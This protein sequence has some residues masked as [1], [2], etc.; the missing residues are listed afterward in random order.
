MKYLDHKSIVHITLFVL[1]FFVV[2]FLFF[3]LLKFLPFVKLSNTLLKTIFFSG[4]TFWY[5]DIEINWMVRFRWWMNCQNERADPGTRVLLSTDSPSIPLFVRRK[6]GKGT[7]L[8]MKSSG[9]HFAEK[10]SCVIWG[11]SSTFCLL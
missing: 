6:C 9:F 5:R 1:F 7:G 2:L 10:H 3:A 4:Q 11:K 8:E